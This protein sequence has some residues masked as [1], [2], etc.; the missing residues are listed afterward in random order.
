MQAIE[1][2]DDDIILHDTGDLVDDFGAE[3]DLGNNKSYLFEVT[4]RGR[5]LARIRLVPFFINDGVYPASEIDA[6]WLRKTMRERSEPFETTYERAGD[7]FVVELWA[8]RR[9]QKSLAGDV[10]RNQTYSLTPFASRFARG[11]WS[12]ENALAGI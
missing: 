10:N 2:Y 3:D 6:D 9:R 1:Q 4:V 8:G 11:R 12:P 7:G 5:E